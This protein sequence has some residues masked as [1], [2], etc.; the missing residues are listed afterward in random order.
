[1]Y[2][3]LQALSAQDCVTV[4]TTDHGAV[5]GRRSALVHGNRDTSTNLRYKYGVNLNTDVKQAI[6]VRKPMDYMLPDDGVNKNYILAREDFYFVY[7]TRFHDYEIDVVPR[8]G[9]ALLF[10]HRVWHEGC[11]VTS[12][13]KYVLRSDVMYRT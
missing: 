10:Q 7:P 1:L 4:I 3:I 9:M 11:E 6:I 2:E 8:T 13:V 12:G 5:Q